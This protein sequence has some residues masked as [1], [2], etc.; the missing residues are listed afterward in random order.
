M[1][2]L[3]KKA[4]S[5]RSGVAYQEYHCVYGEDAETALRFLF[6]AMTPKA[7]PTISN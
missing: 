5:D 7:D 2:I 6:N 4:P 1:V 3:L